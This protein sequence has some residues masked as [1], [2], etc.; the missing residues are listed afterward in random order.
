M[1]AH[2]VG[3]ICRVMKKHELDVGDK[4]VNLIRSWTISFIYTYIPQV[5]FTET[6]CTTEHKKRNTNMESYSTNGASSLVDSLG[7]EA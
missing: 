2:D 4:R 3:E 6:Q 7:V 5:P 1:R